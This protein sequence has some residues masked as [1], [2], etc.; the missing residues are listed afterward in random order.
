MHRRRAGLAFL[1]FLVA[2]PSG[3]QYFGQNKVRYETLD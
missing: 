2:A 1:F 3:A